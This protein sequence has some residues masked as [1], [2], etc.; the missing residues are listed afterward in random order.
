M[1]ACALILL[2]SSG[3]K[4]DFDTAENEEETIAEEPSVAVSLA[5]FKVR[6]RSTYVMHMFAFAFDMCTACIM[7]N[8]SSRFDG[9]VVLFACLELIPSR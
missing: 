1:D 6:Y 4:S 8:V 7:Q 3:S 9:P 5:R 2:S